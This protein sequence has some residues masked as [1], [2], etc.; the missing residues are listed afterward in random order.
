MAAF[1]SF[2][3][4]DSFEWTRSKNHDWK[5]D[6]LPVPGEP[7]R[8]PVRLAVFH[9]FHT[10]ES[11]GDHVYPLLL[12]SANGRADWKLGPEIAETSTLGLRIRDHNIQAAVDV[13]SKTA[14][15][16][17]TIVVERVPGPAGASERRDFGL[18]RI[19]ED[20]ELRS[21][22][23]EGGRPVPFQQA[24][25]IVAFVPPNAD[26]FTLT[27]EYGGTLDHR[28]GD[29]IHDDEAV[30]ISYWYPHIARLPATL[31][32]AATAPTG[33]TPIAQGEPVENHANADGSRTYSWRNNIPTSFF[34]LDMGRYRIST[35]QWNGRLLSAYLLGDKPDSVE[36]LSRETLDLLQESLAF[37]EKTI[38][39]FPYR[40]YAIVETRGP[41]NGA[42]EAYSFATFGPRTLPDYIPH[43]LAHT[44]FGGIVP[45]AY[46]R[47]MWNE[48]FANYADDLFRRAGRAKLRAKAEISASTAQRLEVRRQPASPYTNSSVESAFDTDDDRQNAVGYS[49]GAQILR[50]LEEEIGQEPMIRAIQQFVSRHPR[51]EAAEWPEFEAAVEQVTGWDQRWFFAQWIARAGVPRVAMTDITVRK[52]GSQTWIDGNVRQTGPLYRLKLPVSVELRS[53]AAVTATVELRD[54]NGAF[55][56]PI[57]GAPD[58]V[59]LDPEALGPMEAAAP[60]NG[61]SDPF[62]Y[63]FP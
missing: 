46:T 30:I 37:Y 56:I 27:T 26:R 34:T 33:W 29:Y 8:P 39:P 38:G 3:N 18:L 36:R 20:F 51:G 55:H 17:D 14:T 12:E 41:F 62:T 2:E 22:R 4:G 9:A 21:L 32:I 59:R 54:V 7:E 25:G 13:P 63:Q 24:G 40:R 23:A 58:R 10:C 15:F 43:E 53:G 42:L 35:R 52:E 44:W 28:N 5:A 61:S 11:D 60:A 47:S 1:R 50:L 16:R 57:A 19:S 48:A 31:S 45:C 49:K 6:V